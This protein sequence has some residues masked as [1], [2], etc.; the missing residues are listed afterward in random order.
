MSTHTAHVQWHRGEEPF[1]DNRFSRRHT[2]SFD[3][4]AVLPG[5]SSPHIT[6]VPFSDPS[7]V[8]PEETFVA[9]LS[10]CH[11]L[12]FLYIAASRRIRV[13]SYSDRAEG[14]LAQNH[15]GRSM[16]S[17]VTLRPDV[18]FSGDRPPS[19]S[20]VIAMHDEAHHA[21][22]IANSVL[23]DVRCEPVLPGVS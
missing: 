13:D 15:G 12:W 16:M 5:S 20:D 1:V 6:R 18:R 7:A 14:T 23:T 22:F 3:G 9:S 17:V 2:I 4:G 8:D 19:P 21:C 11:M 10:S